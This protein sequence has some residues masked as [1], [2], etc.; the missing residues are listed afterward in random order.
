MADN[1]IRLLALD[2]GGVRGLSS[3]V[4]LRNL[5]VAIDPKN[6]PKPCDYFDMIGGTS[7]GGLLAVMLGRLRMSID[8]C[9]NSYMSLSDEVFGKKNGVLRLNGQV[10]ARFD[11]IVLERAIKKIVVQTGHDEDALL[12]DASNKCRVFVCA[13]SKET[14]DTVSLTSYRTARTTHLVSCTTIVDACRATSAATT[15]FDPVVIGPFGEQ[16]IDGALGANN[17]VGILWTEAQ[18]VWGSRLRAD[19]R[20]LVSIGTGM[21][22]LRP[23]AYS[24]LGILM[25]LKGLATDTERIAEQFRRENADLDDD[26]RYFRFNVI[27]GLERIGLEES[28][29]KE[30][31][32]WATAQYLGTQ[33][34]KKELMKC[35][36]SLAKRQNL[37]PQKKPSWLTG[38]PLSDNFVDRPSDLCRL[39]KCLLPSEPQHEGKRT[40]VIYG[41]GGVGKT[42]LAASFAER[43]Q[44]AFSSILWLDGRCEERLRRSL[45]EFVDKIPEGQFVARPRQQ[46]EG[47]SPEDL[48]AAVAGVLN[49]LGRSDNRDWLLI[50]D[51][52]NQEQKQ[53]GLTEYDVSRYVS[54]DHGSVLITTRDSR[55]AQLAPPGNSCKLE[56]A[57]NNLGR[58]IFEAWYG[59]TI[60][61]NAESLLSLLTHLNGLP[62]ALAQAASYMRET[63]VS[64]ETYV[65]LYKEQCEKLARSET[66]QQALKLERMSILTTWAVSFRHIE[67]RNAAAASLLR[68]WA[69]L[70]NKSLW[71][72]LLA[73]TA[74]DGSHQW[75]EWLR[76]LAGSKTRYLEAISLLLS[77]SM[78]E[79]QRSSQNSY[80]VHP[81]VHKWASALDGSSVRTE[82]ARLGLM[83]VGLAV[84]AADDKDG[85]VMQQR[86]LPHAQQCA[87]WMRNRSPDICKQVD[88]TILWPLHN[89]GNLFAVQGK[90]Q[91][92]EYMYGSAL[93]GREIALGPD[94][95]DTLKT[96]HVLGGLYLER[97]K[98]VEAEA[99]Y[100]RVLA[101]YQKAFGPDHTSA[102]GVTNDLGNLYK[103]HGRLAE[104]DAMYLRAFNGFCEVLGYN[105]PTTQMVTQKIR[106]LVNPFDG[107]DW[108]CG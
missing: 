34:V 40:F 18:D 6:P 43:H 22:A 73:A 83:M 94:H 69:F 14:A 82:Y 108:G 12:K 92:A 2:G 48:D 45:S 51:G 59:S 96:V 86:L 77:Y 80:E 57:D 97:G 29:R 65:R 75:P 105:H 89:L 72:G 52:I 103:Q 56:K 50:F 55:L 76:E 85:W 42:Q 1:E 4:I 41:L 84:P 31:I 64:V 24:A 70:G 16:F 53:N 3:L 47:C 102:L 30:E 28:K 71:H 5:M 19:L 98:L 46:A 49:W 107:R 100:K 54:W 101:G 17:P 88:T 20:C 38:V 106:N 60:D 36:T 35:A 7:T 27:H 11:S 37:D 104:A 8:D 44:S 33:E 10:R 32:V 25:T 90:L 26:G 9:I 23:V 66:G 62:L 99:M 68:V 13:T 87:I 91:E 81:V 78:I 21:R 93:A 95:T 79:E 61:S 15:F 58:A 74:A 63:R 67:K 39:E